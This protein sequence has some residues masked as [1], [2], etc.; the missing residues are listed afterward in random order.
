[1]KDNTEY[2]IKTAAYTSSGTGPWSSEFKG[3]TLK[4]PL[5]DKY[6][7]IIWSASE[8]LLTSDVIGENVQ[9]LIHKA[10]MKDYYIT[11]IAWY[12]DQLYL[13]SNTSHIHWYN[14]TSHKTGKLMDIDSV[15]SAA[16][17]WIG[18]KLYW[19]NPKQQLVSMN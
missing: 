16:V 15:G 17:D 10:N 1:M 7:S 13:V 12:E 2:V 6:P 19:S 9:T 5:N 11:D 14:M 18:K 3:K 4:R 8:G